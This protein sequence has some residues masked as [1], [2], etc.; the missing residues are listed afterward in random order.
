MKFQDLAKQIA[1]QLSVDVPIVRAVLLARGS[2]QE[3]RKALANSGVDRA[4]MERIGN[5]ART[6]IH[7]ELL[8]LDAR[9]HPPA[10]KTGRHR[11]GGPPRRKK[12]GGL[13][14]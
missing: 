11:R 9:A 12:K 1:A 3:M 10:R 6:L 2:P 4:L 14:R 8:R 13:T 7:E 5:A